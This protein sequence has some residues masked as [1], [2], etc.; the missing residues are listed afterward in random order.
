MPFDGDFER[1][2]YAIQSKWERYGVK[3]IVIAYAAFLLCWVF[4]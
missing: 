3:G 4:Q 1:Y 2:D